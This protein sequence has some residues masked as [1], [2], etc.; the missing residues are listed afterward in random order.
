ML[1]DGFGVGLGEQ[2]EEC[3]A[4]VVR[5]AIRIA[6]LI[7]NGVDEQVASLAVQ[8]GDKALEDVAVRTVARVAQVDMGGGEAL[9]AQC[10][11]AVGAHVDDERVHELYVVVRAGLG[12]R[13]QVGAQVAEKGDRSARLD[14]RVEVALELVGYVVDVGVGDLGRTRVDVG[15]H[16]DLEVGRERI[17]QLHGARK[18]ALHQVAQLYAVG[19]YDV[20]ELVVAVAQ[21]LGKV[22]QQH[23]EETQAALVEQHDRLGEL[24]VAQEGR[25]ELDQLRQ[26]GRVHVPILERL[27]TS[28]RCSSDA[29]R[30]CVSWW[31]WWWWWR[32]WAHLEHLGD[33]EA[34]SDE[35]EPRVGEAGRLARPH[36]VI[37]VDKGLQDLVDDGLQV[38]LGQR[39]L[40]QQHEEEA[41][42]GHGLEL[43]QLGLLVVEQTAGD[44]AEHLVEQVDLVDVVGL[45]ARV[46]HQQDDELDEGVEALV[47]RLALT[48][49]QQQ[50]ARVDAYLGAD[51]EE[52]RDHVVR[53]EQALAVHLQH[54]LLEDL[55]VL[56][57]RQDGVMLEPVVEQLIALLLEASRVVEVARL[58]HAR[59]HHGQSGGAQ[60]TGRVHLVALV[61]HAYHLDG[62]LE[63]HVL[64]SVARHRRDAR[65]GL[66]QIAELHVQIGAGVLDVEVAEEGERVLQ[67][68]DVARVDVLRQVHVDRL[69]VEQLVLEED[70]EAV[71]RVLEVLVALVPYLVHLFHYPVAGAEA[72][73][74]KYH[75]FNN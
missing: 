58:L 42:K 22:V 20:A 61:V 2:V 47:A 69:C 44:E 41:M 59:V 73:I 18:G 1:L 56:L 60:A 45:I 57:L 46:L 39:G 65:H 51:A 30:R 40:E 63:L 15:D 38:V 28:C 25:Q 54:E 48:F 10:L 17:G 36:D 5:V 72:L 6:E 49:G 9:G 14:V 32:R 24:D 53:F 4:E 21:E 70:G 55:G 16:V 11:D 66:E 68:L 8:V 19:R 74:A 62:V 29:S 37:D 13:L 34:M 75:L 33:E 67:R 31:W 71:H 50:V 52:A 12:R 43:A 23:E 26:Q 27:I 7:G 3:A 64:L 35:L